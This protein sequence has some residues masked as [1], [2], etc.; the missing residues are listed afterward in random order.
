MPV[1]KSDLTGKFTTSY[2]TLGRGQDAVGQV[3]NG[4][5]RAAGN[6]L[7]AFANAADV[8]V[9]EKSKETPED[10]LYKNKKER[11]INETIAT[12]AA[13]FRY[14]PEEFLEKAQ[15]SKETVLKDVPDDKWDW[16][17]QTYEERINGYH[18]TIVNNKLALNRQQQLQ[19]FT[20]KSDEYRDA[21]MT[22]AANG[23]ALAFSQNLVKWREN[24]DFMFNNGFMDGAKKTARMKEFTNT[25][26][27]QQNIA[28]AKQL[29]GDT[30]Q[31]NSFLNNIDKSKTY[32]PELKRSIKQSVLSEY[33]NWSALNKVKSAEVM[34]KAD[35]GIKAYSMG[36]E[37]D[38]FDVNDTIAELKASGQTEKAAQ[39]ENAFEL[40]NEMSSFA[41]LAPAQMS[42]E[43]AELK[44]NASDQN[45][46][47]RIQV[48]EKLA[49]T[50]QK[51]ISNDALS[52]AISHKVVKDD[53][54]DFNKPN[55]LV[56]RQKNAAFL[57]EKYGLDKKPLM[58]KGEIKTLQATLA[59]ADSESKAAMLATLSNSFGEDADQI[60]ESVSEKNPEFAVAGKIFTRD[61]ITAAHIVEGTAIAANEKGFA[62]SQNAALNNAFGRLDQALSNFDTKDV[63]KVKQAVIANMTY[64]N[65]AK[66]LYK[67]GDVLDS[68]KVEVADE[69]IEQVLGNKIVRMSVGDG[70]FGERYYTVLP[71][72]TTQDAFEDWLKK[73]K[74]N[75]I[76]NAFIGDKRVSAKTIQDN[77]QLI[78][79]GDNQYTV[80]INGD[81]VRHADGSP[82]ILTYGGAK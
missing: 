61:P 72:D 8:Y 41:S 15:K 65:K 1:Q 60:F 73:L 22:A 31:L 44:K 5:G 27:V 34:K 50:A 6:L 23:D 47:N 21:A 75:E 77:G 68:D 17:N 9:R 33:N 45:D 19:D 39:L 48:L 37:P 28:G 32:T 40:K 24:E 29:F 4:V 63:N 14:K 7:N 30:V 16:V 74:D 43:L 76:N 13:T 71:P 52:F 59:N 49:D 80:K 46:L 12:D 54:I 79:D 56:E 67:D 70:W 36:L 82:L 53:G 11:E 66:N 62:P 38:G 51:E 69:A 20:A 55:T 58:T 3:Y 78:Y 42:S 18:Q 35:F 10:R 2:Q 57:Q 81:Y 25:A 64:L 26:V